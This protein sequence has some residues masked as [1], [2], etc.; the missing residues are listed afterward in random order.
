MVQNLVAS[1][2]TWQAE[3]RSGWLHER[4]GLEPSRSS[5]GMLTFGLSRGKPRPTRPTALR[6]SQR[7][8]SGFWTAWPEQTTV[9]GWWA[10]SVGVWQ[11]R[12][13]RGTRNWPC[14]RYN[15]VCSGRGF[16]VA[17]W[18]RFSHD[19]AMEFVA[20]AERSR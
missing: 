2:N 12:P 15:G 5:C 14:G 3:W 10:F 6:R 4:R 1:W 9:S 18:R 7:L 11:A 20:L 19:D 8:L 13:A 16:S 17:I